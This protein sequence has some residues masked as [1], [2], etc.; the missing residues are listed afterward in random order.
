MNDTLGFPVALALGFS[1]LFIDTTSQLIPKMTT[2]QYFDVR[3]ISAERVGDSAILHVDREIYAPIEMSFSVR[4]M[5][6]GADGWHQFCKMQAEP[7]QY[8]PEAVLP[9]PTILSW[10]TDGKCVTLPPGPAQIITTW[11]PANRALAPITVIARV[12]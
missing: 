8:R 1:G 6:E 5:A 7:F 3:S 2:A 9:T 11:S 4:I 10:W 12:E